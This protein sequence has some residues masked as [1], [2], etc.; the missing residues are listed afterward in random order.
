[1]KKAS[2]IARYLLALLLVVFGLNKFLGFMPAP[3]YVMNPPA[4]AYMIG[5]SGTHI[6]PVLGIIYLLSAILLSIDK[7]VGLATVVL[8]A[9]AFNFLLFHLVLDPANLAP[10][11]VFTALLVLVMIGNKEKYSGLLS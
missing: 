6:F 7:M 10:G 1:M 4:M 11:I 9:I 8:A 3:D 5:L 2:L